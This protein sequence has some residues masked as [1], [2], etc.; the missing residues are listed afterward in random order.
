MALPVD[1]GMLLT[2]GS[3]ATIAAL[4]GSLAVVLRRYFSHRA[5]ELRVAKKHLELHFHAVNQILDDPAVGAKAKALI[6]MF[7]AAVGRREIAQSI[8]HELMNGKTEAAD[9]QAVRYVSEAFEEIRLL[10]YR[11]DLQAQFSQAFRSGFLAMVM[12]FP[13]TEALLPEATLIASN[14]N[15]A[16][17]RK[18]AVAVVS[19]SHDCKPLVHVAAACL[20]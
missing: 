8:A 20:P 13:E 14:E 15:D 12:R 7:S 19:S 5:D 11:A 10:S 2:V 18:M 6:A 17:S 4:G 3:F 16:S 1:I 9:P